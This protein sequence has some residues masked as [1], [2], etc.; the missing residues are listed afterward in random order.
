VELDIL[1]TRRLPTTALEGDNVLAK[2][3]SAEKRH[4]QSL[5]RNARNSAARS[6]MRTAIKHAR[7]ALS[8]KAPDKDAR[9]KTAVAEI[10]RA[11][12]KNLI[13]D[14]TASRYVSRLM[15]AAAS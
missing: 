9:V 13:K 15:R 1:A 5:K 8:G 6:K 11:A 12:A 3:K 2:H 7:A 4:R 10:Y 14:E